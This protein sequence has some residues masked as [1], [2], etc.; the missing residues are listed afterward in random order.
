ML[1]WELLK[2]L[3]ESLEENVRG[4]L[5][6]LIFWL[7]WRRMY[8][9]R[10]WAQCRW[11]LQEY[12]KYFSDWNYLSWNWKFIKKMPLLGAWIQMNLWGRNAKFDFYDQWNYRPEWICKSFSNERTT[13][14]SLKIMRSRNLHQ[15]YVIYLLTSTQYFIGG[16]K[17]EA[18]YIYCSILL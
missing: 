12:T 2:L 8:I 9:K 18:N 16:L 6:F 13:A 1:D 11:K 14:L 5:L 17:F 3:A 7:R 10:K 15:K 4:E